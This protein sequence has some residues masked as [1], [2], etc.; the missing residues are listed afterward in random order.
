MPHD[1]HLNPDRDI[2]REDGHEREEERTRCASINISACL[3]ARSLYDAAYHRDR[4]DAVVPPPKPQVV[5]L[6]DYLRAGGMKAGA[7]ALGRG[8][9]LTMLLAGALIVTNGVQNVFDYQRAQPIIHIGVPPL[10]VK[11]WINQD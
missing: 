5:S 11:H 10:P 2:R 1:D 6:W 8:L 9:Q 4:G 7:L 3:E